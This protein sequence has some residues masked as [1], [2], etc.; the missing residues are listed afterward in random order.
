MMQGRGNV[1]LIVIRV[2]KSG[3]P[4]FTQTV[5]PDPPLQTYFVFQEGLTGT[6]CG[7]DVDLL[8]LEAENFPG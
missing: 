6:Y 2:R 7:I 3:T 8:G 4:V 1:L 5:D